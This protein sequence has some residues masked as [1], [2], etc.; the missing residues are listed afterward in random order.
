M[1]EVAEKLGVPVSHG[2]SITSGAGNIPASLPDV[3]DMTID[4][5]GGFFGVGMDG[6]AFD[7]TYPLDIGLEP[8]WGLNTV[9]NTL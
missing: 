1:R 4:L 5:T 8:T 9:S 3:M 7:W 6:F 2:T